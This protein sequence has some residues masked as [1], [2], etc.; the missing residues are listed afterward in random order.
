MEKQPELVI[1]VLK[2]MSEAGILD[3]ILLIGSWCTSFYKDY[4]KGTDY[5]P[6]IKTRDID[7]SDGL[8]PFHLRTPSPSIVPNISG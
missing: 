1:K 3:H 2:R 4:F 5:A 8:R 6:T 7:F